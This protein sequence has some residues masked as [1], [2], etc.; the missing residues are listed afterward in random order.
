MAV[1]T[2]ERLKSPVNI[3][4]LLNGIGGLIK[5]DRNK[6]SKVNPLETIFETS[7]QAIR[8]PS[9]SQTSTRNKSSA[10]P[11]EYCRYEFF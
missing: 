7:C 4:P 8:G 5:L 6:V 9:L 2:A 3:E 10:L 11:I 1:A